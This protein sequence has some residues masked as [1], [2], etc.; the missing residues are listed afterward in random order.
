MVSTK[1]SALTVGGM[2][3]W[4]ATVASRHFRMRASMI[5]LWRVMVRSLLLPLLPWWWRCGCPGWMGIDALSILHKYCRKYANYCSYSTYC[6]VNR[7]RSMLIQKSGA[8]VTHFCLCAQNI[9][10]ILLPDTV[11]RS[12]EYCILYICHNHSNSRYYR[13]YMYFYI[14]QHCQSIIRRITRLL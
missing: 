3:L 13:F 12:R 14:D 7:H 9:S 5:A 2:S 11:T 6:V 1:R 4:A 10:I 8:A